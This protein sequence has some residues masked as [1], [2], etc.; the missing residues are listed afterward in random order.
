MFK[1]R[2]IEIAKKFNIPYRTL[3]NFKNKTDY[4]KDVVEIMSDMITLEEIAQ[5]NLS[6]FSNAE[7]T[8]IKDAIDEYL[9]DV[10]L[11]KKDINSSLLD[12]IKD[13]TKL[14]E[15]TE[16]KILEDYLYPNPTLYKLDKLDKLDRYFLIKERFKEVEN[17]LNKV[18]FN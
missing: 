12:L 17:Y 7:I 5:E 16:E 6:K 8:Y 18:K 13:N 14:K 10:I 15:L 9:T 1:V 4:R 11:H 3:Q 2:L